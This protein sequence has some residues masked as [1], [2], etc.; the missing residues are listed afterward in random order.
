MRISSGLVHVDGH[1]QRASIQRL[2]VWVWI[3][4]LDSK[5]AAIKGREAQ[6][7]ERWINQQSGRGS[8]QSTRCHLLQDC[9]EPVSSQRQ[10]RLRTQNSQ[11]TTREYAPPK[12][13]QT[14]NL[15]HSLIVVPIIPRAGVHLRVC[16]K[17][18]NPQVLRVLL[19]KLRGQTVSN[20]PQRPYETTDGNTT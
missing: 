3:G 10:A 11:Q 6:Q 12:K 8:Q 1:V 7:S 20:L 13:Q 14:N 4:E 17:E 5:I 9:L 16:S 18:Q 2:L 19:S 15:E